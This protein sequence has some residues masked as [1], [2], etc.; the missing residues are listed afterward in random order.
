MI[1]FYKENELDILVL[2]GTLILGFFMLKFSW[3]IFKQSDW[4][5][6]FFN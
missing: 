4:Y 6:I 1:K 2:I 5:P 3:W